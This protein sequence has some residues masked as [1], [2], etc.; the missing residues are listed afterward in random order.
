MKFPVF[1]GI[2]M[3]ITSYFDIYFT[4]RNDFIQFAL[5]VPLQGLQAIC[6]FPGSKCW[7][8]N[9]FKFEAVTEKFF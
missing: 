7:A 6:R 5:F 8:C 9:G 1:K 4:I 3:H 2:K